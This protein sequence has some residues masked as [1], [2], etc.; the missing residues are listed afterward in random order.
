MRMKK[1]HRL[2][3]QSFCK[4]RR[5]LPSADEL[6]Q[7]HVEKVGRLKELESEGED[8][9]GPDTKALVKTLTLDVFDLAAGSGT[10]REQPFMY[11]APARDILDVGCDDKV[12]VQGVMDLVIF[13]EKTVLV[14]YKVSGA[15]EKTLRERY[16]GQLR[17]YAEALGKATGRYPDKKLLVLLNRAEALEI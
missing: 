8:V 13:G 9:S 3:N 14:D 5:L 15:S 16:S 2:F 12:L 6:V 1:F 11:Y 7:C 10:L 17:L 4:A